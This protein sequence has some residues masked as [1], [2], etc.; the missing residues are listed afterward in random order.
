MPGHG[1]LAISERTGNSSTLS[2]V[3]IATGSKSKVS[4]LDD[5]AFVRELS[6]AP[7][8][9][10]A[11]A[12]VGDDPT[13]W[14]SKSLIEIDLDSGQVRA[15]VSA[16]GASSIS[17]PSF[18]TDEQVAY[19]VASPVRGIPVMMLDLR[20]LGSREYA[21]EASQRI[22]F[23]EG[24]AAIGEIVLVSTLLSDPDERLR[25]SIGSPE[26]APNVLGTLERTPRA[27]TSDA[28]RM[29]VPVARNTRVLRVVVVADELDPSPVRRARGSR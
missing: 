1:R 21:D 3:D 6:I 23:A 4:R 26:S 27:F 17:D 29:I 18:V 28:K 15:V 8:G 25:L 7:S 22:Y 14:T 16:A 12:A 9:R 24:A 2:L 10:V 20:T 11:V 5:G 19:S 13:L